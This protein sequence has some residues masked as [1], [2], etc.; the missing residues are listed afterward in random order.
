MLT[1]S[2][3]NKTVAIGNSVVTVK[4]AEKWEQIFNEDA[5]ENDPID[6]KS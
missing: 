1:A 5:K 6:E 4:S 3:L 2:L